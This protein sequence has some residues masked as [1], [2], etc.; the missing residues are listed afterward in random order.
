M[1]IALGNGFIWRPS[2]PKSLINSARLES[3]H[4][5]SFH[6]AHSSSIK[7]MNRVSAFVTLL[8]APCNPFA[9]FGAIVAVIINSLKRVSSWAFSH[10]FQKVFK[11]IQPPFTYGNSSAAIVRVFFSMD[12]IAPSFHFNPRRLSRT[13]SI[14]VFSISFANIGNSFLF[15]ASATFGF[16]GSNVESQNLSFS[17]ASAF[18]NRSTPR[19]TNNNP[20]TVL[21]SNA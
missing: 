7:I 17:S 21:I 3:K 8:L 1:N 2:A 16:S 6:D 15:G 4:F 11:A 10:I 19:S 12:S 13:V 5:S 14:A 18:T 20:Q 9:V